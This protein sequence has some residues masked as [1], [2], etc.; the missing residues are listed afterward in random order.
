MPEP[1]VPARGRSTRRR[2]A[3]AIALAGVMLAGCATMPAPSTPP[4]GTAP[5]SVLRY[6]ATRVSDQHDA[7]HG[8]DIADPGRWLEDLGSAEVHDWVEAQNAVSQSF[9][10]A[11]PAREPLRARLAALWNYERWGASLSGTHSFEVPVTRGGRT[12]YL[13]NIGSDDQSVLMVAD[14]PEAAP[15][16]VLDPNAFAVDRTVALTSFT[17][18]PDGRHVAY[19]TADGGTDWKTIRIRNVEQAAD[20]PE[21]LGLVK[22]TPLAWLPDGTGFY[23]SRYPLAD[24]TRGDDTRQVAV[25]F[26]ALDTP[27]ASDRFVYAITDHPTRNPYATVTDDG[28]WLVVSV[29]DGFASNGVYLL[30]RQAPDE[31]AIRLLDRWD[32]RYEF[33]GNRDRTFYFLTTV[34]APNGRIVAID[35]D[36]PATGDWRVLVPES[37]DVIDGA[38][39][40]GG[41]FV[42]RYLHDA[43]SIVRIHDLDGAGA[44]D[45]ELPGLG[46]VLGLEGRDADRQLYFAY[47]DFLTPHALYRLDVASGRAT[48]YRRPSVALDPHRYVTEQVFATSRDGTR[49]PVYVTHRR[50]VPRDGRRPTMLYGYGGFNVPLLP[51]FSVPVAVWLEQGGVYAVAN[52]RGGA[53]YGEAWHRAGT[54]TQKQHTF[55]DFIAASEWLIAN[56]VTSR[57]HLVIRGRSNGGLLVGAVLLQRPDL[58]AAALPVVGVMDMLRYHTASANARQWSSDYGLSEDAAEFRALRAYSPVHNVRRGTCYPPTLVTTAEHD[59]RV[60]PWHSYKFAAA[61][62]AA[63]PSACTNPMLLRVETRAGHGNDR[64][65]WMQVEDYAD[66]WAFA[67]RYTGLE[68]KP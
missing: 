57:E 48:P 21:Q 2:C 7:Y 19:A 46:E 66:Q 51:S 47:T 35:L 41:R 17:V 36:R 54:T 37:P 43:H 60:M 63:V 50:D 29:S 58:Y 30:D 11:L 61:L 64:P 27:Q 62:Q 53:E 31:D 4:T 15:R 55:D 6:P 26:H 65:V 28:R 68:V 67:A 38:A 24:E 25:W 1:A 18:S 8:I 13:Y 3:S 52:L 40:A 33:L 39:L 22:F 34:G 44:T 10:G 45:V 56:R 42:V 49:V 20:L 23:Y 5:M 14:D 16:P 59:D 12:F 32:A 9:L